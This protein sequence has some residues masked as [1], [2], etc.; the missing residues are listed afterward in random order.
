MRIFAGLLII[1]CCAGFLVKRLYLDGGGGGVFGPVLYLDQKAEEGFAKGIADKATEQLKPDIPLLAETLN[2]VGEDMESSDKTSDEVLDA[3][4]K[5]AKQEL[6]D[7]RW[8]AWEPYTSDF[9]DR[10]RELREAE[11]LPDAYNTSMLFQF[12]AAGLTQD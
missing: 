5:K 11:H 10:M 4:I 12:W 7:A 3:W 6:G 1:L 9:G 2:D 8:V